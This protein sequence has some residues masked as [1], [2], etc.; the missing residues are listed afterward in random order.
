MTKF[1]VKQRKELGDNLAH[2][3]CEDVASE[4]IDKVVGSLHCN[5]FN[6]RSQT[7]LNSCFSASPKH[8]LTFLVV[9]DS[10]SASRCVRFIANLGDR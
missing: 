5:H 6:D 2:V 3:D 4:A 9:S 8:A 7:L 10:I 1:P